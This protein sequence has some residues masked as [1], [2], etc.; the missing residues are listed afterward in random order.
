MASAKL[1]TYIIEEL[2]ETESMPTVNP[3]IL[4]WARMTAG[5][6][7]EEAAKAI[8]I[9]QTS[10]E[11]LE[12]GERA[13]SYNQLNNMADKYRRPL[14]AFYLQR[15]PAQGDRGEDFRRLPGSTLSDFDPKLD[16][17]IR[18]IR[19]RH[20]VVKSLLEDEEIGQLHF[21]GSKTVT[22]NTSEVA[23]AIQTAVG[24]E[25]AEFRKAKDQSAAFTYLR[26]CFEKSG[27]FVLL[28][29]N[30]G[31]YHSNISSKTFRG[32]AVSDKIAP[33]IIINDN[34]APAAWSFT[35]FHEAAH[36]W[37]GQTG[38]S[39]SSEESRIERFCNEVASKILLPVTDIQEL[40]SIDVEKFEDVFRMISEF[41]SGRNV[42]RRMIAYQLLRLERIDA[43]LYQR[44]GERLLDDWQSSRE[45]E[46]ESTDKKTQVNRYVVLR[47]RLGPALINLA[48]RSLNRG[49]LSPTKASRLLGVKAGSVS[50]LLNPTPRKGVV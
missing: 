19:A 30:L 8:G 48:R 10:L 37:L 40:K 24:F 43:V 9:K 41:A 18:D 46:K 3:D 50:A 22:D 49:A 20:N 35:A 11:G 2:N 7:L 23:Q 5:M 34:D 31:S 4:A 42:S 26:G 39:G 29:G 27:I 47:H 45:R 32:Y 13:P 12:Q 16:A 17:L 36:L 28:L 25:L 38:V 6:S 14:I 1:H 33:T 15:P 44:I 21:I